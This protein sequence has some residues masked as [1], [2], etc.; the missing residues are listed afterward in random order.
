MASDGAQ[1]E[2]SDGN[3]IEPDRAGKQ[4]P[5]WSRGFKAVA[6]QQADIEPWKVVKLRSFTHISI[7]IY[8]IGFSWL[9]IAFHSFS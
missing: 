3:R 8:Y 5:A 2:D 4:V 9:V 6:A 1:E 7:Y